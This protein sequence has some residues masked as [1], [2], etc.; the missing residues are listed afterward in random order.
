M[1][2]EEGI[3]SVFA[4]LLATATARGNI[5]EEVKARPEAEAEA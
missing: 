2:Y 3:S 5:V 4:L 1:A